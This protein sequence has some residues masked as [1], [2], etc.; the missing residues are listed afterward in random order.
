[1]RPRLLAA[2]GRFRHQTE[3]LRV[4]DA[5]PS[6]WALFF[7]FFSIGMYGF[8]GVL[9]WARRM[10][11]DQRR[12]L[13][14]AEFTDLLALCQFLPGPNI[15]N[16]SVALGARYRGLPG[17]I[18]CFMGLMAAPFGIVLVLATV[19]DRFEDIV[20]VQNAFAGLSAAASG[21]IV[22]MAIKVVSPLRGNWLGIGVAAT[23]FVAVAGF[24]APLLPALLVLAPVG[25][26]LV[27]LADRQGWNAR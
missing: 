11:V 5:A 8:G 6:L 12:W 13:T 2:H 1:M 14:P 27:W 10:V 19:Y 4:A 25:I 3:E 22:V 9:P 24:R 7:G 15:V 23:G 18:A 16:M 26:L 17:A 20:W 21:L